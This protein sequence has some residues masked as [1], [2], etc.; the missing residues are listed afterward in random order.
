MLDAGLVDTAFSYEKELIACS[1][2]QEF[3]KGKGSSLQL[4]YNAQTTFLLCGMSNTDDVIELC[5]SALVIIATPTR[6]EISLA[7]IR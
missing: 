2:L 5:G 1:F 3:S 7:I 4:I 6:P